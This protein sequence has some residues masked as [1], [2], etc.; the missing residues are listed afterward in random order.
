MTLKEIKKKLDNAII[1]IYS[2]RVTEEEV[3]RFSP[4]WRKLTG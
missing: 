4:F 1:V 2:K 3:I